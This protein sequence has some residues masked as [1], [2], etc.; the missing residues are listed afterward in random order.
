M[1]K[2]ACMQAVYFYARQQPAF[3]NLRVCRLP[4]APV[5]KLTTCAARL[6]ARCDAPSSAASF[7]LVGASA[8]VGRLLVGRH[9]VGRPW[10]APWGVCPL[11]ERVMVRQAKCVLELASANRGCSRHFQTEQPLGVCCPT[12]G[13][14]VV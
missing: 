3:S 11:R 8:L 10:R 1:D 7:T 9:L 14:G 13:Q 6:V 5:A 12:Q 2:V 4:L